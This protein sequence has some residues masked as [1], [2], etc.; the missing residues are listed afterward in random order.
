VRTSIEDLEELLSAPMAA[1][2]VFA[3]CN[4]TTNRQAQT[5]DATEAS[6]LNWRDSSLLAQIISSGL[7]QLR[8]AAGAFSVITALPNT[9]ER[10]V[11]AL[12]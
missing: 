5:T 10:R 1:K 12:G 6:Q 4:T 3:T 11:C 7:F 8:A 2:L 9:L